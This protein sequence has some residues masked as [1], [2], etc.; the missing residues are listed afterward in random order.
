MLE[1]P[2]KRFAHVVGDFIDWLAQDA[3]QMK[4]TPDG[5]FFWGEING[6]TPQQPYVF[7]YWVGGDTRIGDPYAE[8]VADPWNDR[9]IPE[10][11]FPDL[12]TYDRT[13]FGI[14]AV[15][16]TGQ[17][18]FVWDASEAQWQRPELDHLVI[19]ELLVRDFLASY[20]Y[21]Y[22]T[23]TLSYLKR[24]GV[25]AIELMPFNEFE[26]NE[27]WGYNPS[28]YL[29][30]DKYY[31]TP[32]DLKRFIQA[33]HQEGLAVIMDMVLNHAYRQNALVQL[34]FDPSTGKTTPNNP[35]F[36][37]DYIGDGGW[38]HDFD[39]ESPYTERFID[40]VNT[41]WLR[42]YHIDGYRFDYTNGFTSYAPGGNTHGYNVPRIENLERMADV[43]WAQE[44]EAYVI[45]EHWG[46]AN[47][48]QELADQQHSPI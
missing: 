39:H 8:Q 30:P 45:L 6:L 46:P 3:Y 25:D 29:A 26:G 11:N 42:E 35:W 17:S 36:N 1:A 27:S 15:L 34:Y 33:A 23:D 16:E 40:R 18:P 10:E 22:L 5:E 43:I 47:E 48:E 7:Q 37:V 28:Y 38:G 21:R 9:F 31:G 12:P 41:H 20:S 4:Q 19:Y 24:L 13:E 32:E 44:S 14:A 2:G